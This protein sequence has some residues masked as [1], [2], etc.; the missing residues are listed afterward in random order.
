MISCEVYYKTVAFST[1]S[2]WQRGSTGPLP[3]VCEIEGNGNVLMGI[4]LHAAHQLLQLRFFQMVEP[5]KRLDLL[6][7]DLALVPVHFLPGQPVQFL[8]AAIFLFVQA[9]GEKGI[10]VEYHL[11]PEGKHG[12]SLATENVSDQEK[13]TVEEGCQ[14]WMPLLQSWL[15][16]NFGLS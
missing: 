15:T 1:P 16:R 8:L 12:L 11:Y 14:S 7:Q 4:H 9:L 3:G 5:E 6:L 2:H 10:P 13:S